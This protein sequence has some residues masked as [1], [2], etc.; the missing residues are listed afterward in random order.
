MLS[1]GPYALDGRVPV[2]RIP[3]IISRVD[4]VLSSSAAQVGVGRGSLS[5]ERSGGVSGFALLALVLMLLTGLTLGQLVP[6]GGAAFE[7]SSVKSTE[8]TRIGLEFYD[9]IEAYF[10]TGQTGALRELVH[11]TFVD[12]FQ[13]QTSARGFGALLRQLETLH[14][15]AAEGRITATPASSSA[16][17]VRFAIS[18]PPRAEATSIL[19]LPVIHPEVIEYIETLRITDGQVAERWSELQTPVT[20]TSLASFSW[21]PPPAS[22]ILPAIK[23]IT[24]LSG[25]SMTLRYGATHI[26]VVESGALTIN[27]DP[28][29]TF[30]NLP[31]F[32][33]GSASLVRD[34]S[35]VALPGAIK[36]V[37]GSSTYQI[38]N[39]GPAVARALLIKVAGFEYSSN[40]PEFS[41]AGTSQYD[42]GVQI[43]LLAGASL[44]SSRKGASSIEIGRVTLAP[45]TRVPEH[46]VEGSELFF[47]EAGIL[48]A[49]FGTCARGCIRTVDG[50]VSSI[51]EQRLIR[52]GEGVGASNGATTSYRVAGEEPVTLLV[53][54]VSPVE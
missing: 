15:F 20:S 12:H 26:I 51:T 7:K 39:D 42:S 22:S 35:V 27:G 21:D 44:E 40:V 48:D 17:L 5:P 19:G 18:I 52:A 16:D 29:R 34:T 38:V 49:D 43:E 37:T 28:G 23:R 33:S 36:V 47:V 11:P 3:M 9:A 50:S 45:G 4:R 53:V 30:S 46:E 13:G 25:S 8:A 1:I 31:E 14:A 32:P 54:T 6:L 2:K 10:A 24:V 41:T